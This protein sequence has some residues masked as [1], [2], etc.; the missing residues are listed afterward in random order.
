MAIKTIEAHR[1]KIGLTA[2]ETDVVVTSAV[3]QNAIIDCFAG[4]EILL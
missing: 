1:R 4:Y 3:L 2:E